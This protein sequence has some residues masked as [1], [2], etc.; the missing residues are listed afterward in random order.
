MVKAWEKGSRELFPEDLR[1]ELI[2]QITTRVIST[3]YPAY[4]VQGGV[5]DALVATGGMVYGIE[6][7]QVFAAMD[8]FEKAEGIDVVPAAGVAVDERWTRAPRPW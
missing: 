5:Y 3:R 4:S 8:M 2:E 6:N 1:P 7:D